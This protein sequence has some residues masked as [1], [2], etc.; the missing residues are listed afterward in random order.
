MGPPLLELLPPED[1]DEV[2][3]PPEL[4][5]LP[6]EELDELPLVDDPEELELLDE[7]PL[8]DTGSSSLQP[9]ATSKGRII[10]ARPR[11]G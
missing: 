4:L 10:A 3:L 2:E 1:D 6:P 9:A 11:V 7:A 5:E 8:L